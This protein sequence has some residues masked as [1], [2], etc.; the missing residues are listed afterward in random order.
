MNTNELKYSELTIDRLEEALGLITDVF[1]EYNAPDYSEEGAET[2]KELIDYEW[3]SEHFEGR[4]GLDM[5]ADGGFVISFSPQLRM[6]ICEDDAIDRIVGVIAT[7]GTHLY[8]MFVDGKYHRRGIARRLFE[9]T[10]EELSPRIM[11]V[12]ASPYAVDVYRKLGFVETDLEQNNWGIR[13]VPMEYV[14]PAMMM[15]TA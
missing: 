5:E 8:W 11:T 12:C 9:M 15:Q 4:A 13:V 10:I 7:L 1:Y 14:A 6:W 3:H 2:F